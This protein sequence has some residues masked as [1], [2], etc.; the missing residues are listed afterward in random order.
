[1]PQSFEA[2]GTELGLAS[3]AWAGTGRFARLFTRAALRHPRSTSATINAGPSLSRYRSLLRS[4]LPLLPRS[5]H[6]CRPPVEPFARDSL[7][8]FVRLPTRRAPANIRR[9]RSRLAF[10]GSLRY[11]SLRKLSAFHRTLVG[12]CAADGNTTTGDP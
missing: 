11:F 12:R 4:L 3:S 5:V 2:F 7:K 9:C 1:M 8:S 10:A 6:N